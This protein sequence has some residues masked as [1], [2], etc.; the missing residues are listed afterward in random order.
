MDLYLIILIAFVAGFVVK[1]IGLPPMIG[2]LVSGFVLFKF[3]SE[4]ID[5]SMFE[6]LSDLGI[7]LL[8]FTI[9]LKINIKDLVSSPVLVG[10]IAPMGGIIL[11]ISALFTLT[12]TVTAW[13]LFDVSLE[14]LAL[15]AFSLSFSSTICI[16]KVFEE[17]GDLKTRHGKVS[18][19]ILVIQDF[20]AVLFLVFAKGSVPEIWAI[21]LLLLIPARILIIEILNRAGHAELLPLTGFFL[22]LGAYSLFEFCGVKGDLGAL[23]I[24][25]LISTHPKSA[26]L[27]KSLMNFKDVFLIGFF[28][29][30]GFS[31][32]PT[33]ETWFLA[34][35]LVLMIPV[36]FVLFYFSLILVGLRARA[37]F[38]SSLALMN[39]SEF[40]LIVLAIAAQK[41][42]V[43]EQWIVATALA[44]SISFV[45]TSVFFNYAHVIFVKF[46]PWIV[47]FERTETLHKTCVN[48]PDGA[49]VLVVGMGRVGSAS[50]DNL[51]PV[52]GDKVWGIDA[53]SD[54]IEG[55]KKHN[56]SVALA[57][58]EDGE[59][60]ESIKLNEI[61]LIMLAL[62][63]MDDMKNAIVQLKL[64]QYTGKIAAITQHSDD[65]QALKNCGADT[66]FN[67]QVEVGQ[68]FALESLNLLKSSA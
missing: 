21:G 7:T 39:F 66:V 44:I 61:K 65:A 15:I 20:A 6:V 19:G 40:G 64:K 26:E 37:A 34:G 14:V 16:A 56:R 25:M 29:S 53:D 57:D 18:L 10:S 5:A 17:K 41:D 47:Y 11:I 54:Q 4:Q 46:K 52:L 68:G 32:L 33:G 13:V 45:I 63:N 42:W 12:S 27:Y 59:F 38:L 55:H 36:K 30:I 31:A 58:A 48:R 8:L 43:S 28:L 23:L 1:Q 22:A 35:L 3:Y 67:Y 60:W 9:G 24:G 62:P 50:Y 2:Y 51:Y 49:E